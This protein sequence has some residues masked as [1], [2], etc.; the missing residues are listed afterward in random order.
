MNSRRTAL[1]PTFLKICARRPGAVRTG[2]LAAEQCRGNALPGERRTSRSI[3]RPER[4][5][6]IASAA[7]RIFDDHAACSPRMAMPVP[8]LR[9]IIPLRI[10]PS[11]L[12]KLS[13]YIQGRASVHRGPHTPSLPAQ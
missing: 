3:S 7:A 2:A 13:C 5:K 8:T 12:G 9:S 4:R 6:M 1:P 11:A 10:M